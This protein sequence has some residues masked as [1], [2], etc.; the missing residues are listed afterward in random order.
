[1]KLIKKVVFLFVVVTVFSFTD[2]AL[3]ANILV[4]D[5]SPNINSNGL[6]SINEA[7]IN[8]N[9]NNQSGSVDCISGNGTDTI[10]INND[11]VFTTFYQNGFNDTSGT[12]FI[13]DSLIVN[14]Q[15]HTLS[16]NSTSLFRF[17]HV[18]TSPI[19]LSLKSINMIGGS[20]YAGGMVFVT[21]MNSL[22]ITDSQF[23]Q[24]SS[25]IEG[26]AIYAN[27]LVDGF[28][29]ESST[30]QGN[31]SGMGGAIFVNEADLN[32]KK[33]KFISNNS[34]WLYGGAISASYGYLSIKDSTFDQNTGGTL[35][36]FGGA[37]LNAN[38]PVYLNNSTFSNNSNTSGASVL[39]SESTMDLNI[40]NSTFSG[41]TSSSGAA[42]S[43][44][45]YD[46]KISVG[47]STFLGN[48]SNTNEGVIKIF[49]NPTSAFIE[50]NIFANNTGGECN[51][52]SL[53]INSVNNLSSDGSCG[54][55]SPTG[56]DPLLVNNGGVTKT[57]KL[58]LGSNAIDTA[59][60]GVPGVKFKCPKTDQR[61][62]PRPF[63]GDNDGVAKCDIGAY[64]YSKKIPIVIG[65]L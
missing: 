45:D 7:I 61:Y 58:N 27:G 32:I 59:L 6:C 35:Y 4:N 14:G 55:V 29:I 9:N 2:K 47:F 52:G 20:A 41:N 11:I 19:S 33:T 37:G 17:F 51:W 5:S 38:V 3:A 21:A 8:S 13:T 64:E 23:I 31:T 28:S 54:S 1:M 16:R 12:P 57:H 56:V 36:T 49:W 26:G 34:S 40:F 25:D 48:N 39:R 10:L 62:I 42:I 24:G 46:S 50:N 60:V 18:T 30:F 15:G 63:D 43:L 22:T 53:N 44:Y 65:S